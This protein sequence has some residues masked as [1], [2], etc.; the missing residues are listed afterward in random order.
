MGDNKPSNDANPIL[1]SSLITDESDPSKEI[2]L[3]TND[4]SSSN[5]PT[6][7]APTGT[8]INAS[9]Q[10][11]DRSRHSKLADDP[12]RKPF[13]LPAFAFTEPTDSDSGDDDTPMLPPS[14]VLTKND[15]ERGIV[16]NPSFAIFFCRTFFVVIN[17]SF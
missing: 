6:E 9:I 14:M 16:L 3:C 12:K 13:T 7:M 10:F 2:G 15:Q 1:S 4:V 11:N 8:A 5:L 17:I